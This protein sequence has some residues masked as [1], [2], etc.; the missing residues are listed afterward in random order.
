MDTFTPSLLFRHIHVYIYIHPST[1]PT[2]PSP[3]HCIFL[4]AHVY[5]HIPTSLHIHTCTSRRSAASARWPASPKEEETS[6]P[7]RPGCPALEEEPEP[8]PKKNASRVGVGVQR[9]RQLLCFGLGGKEGYMV[10]DGCQGGSF[11]VCLVCFPP[12]IYVQTR[13]KKSTHIYTYTLTVSSRPARRGAGAGRPPAPAAGTRGRRSSVVWCC[14]CVIDGCIDVLGQGNEED[15]F[16]HISIVCTHLA[17]TH[18]I[19]NLLYLANRT[20]T[21]TLSSAFKSGPRSSISP[22][23]MVRKEALATAM[24]AFV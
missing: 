12:Y 6:C 5:I 2:H 18:I 10:I 8:T 14:V 3:T 17:S 24:P 7:C 16:L 11:C 19:T 9:T 22:K 23:A 15:R 20:C 13:I 4:Y 1:H 21:I